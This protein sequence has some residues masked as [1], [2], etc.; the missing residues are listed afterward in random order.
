MF[1]PDVRWSGDSLK[2]SGSFVQALRMASK[3]V[4]P[5]RAVPEPSYH[6]CSAVR[7]RN[8]ASQ[9]GAAGVVLADD[10]VDV[11]QQLLGG[12]GAVG[13][14]AQPPRRIVAV[15]VRE[16]PAHGRQ[17]VLPVIG[18]GSR[19]V[20]PPNPRSR[21]SE[22]SVVVSRR[23]FGHRLDHV[24]VLDDLS[25]GIE[26]KHVDHRRAAVAGLTVGAVRMDR[27]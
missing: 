26:A 13:D 14:R 12:A 9:Q 22:H 11:E 24:P 6:R 5:A 18:I 16:R 4:R 1:S 23:P 20:S 7:P 2:R 3:G 19:V 17:P 25:V 8:I 27:D 15:G 21:R 10:A